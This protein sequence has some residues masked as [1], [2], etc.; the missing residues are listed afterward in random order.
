MTQAQKL[1]QST[2]KPAR[3]SKDS[4]YRTRK[5]WLCE[6]RIVGKAEYLAKG[7]N[8]RF[9]VTSIQSELIDVRALYEDFHCA[10]GE[11]ENWIKEQQLALFPDC[12]STSWMRSDQLRRYVSSFAFIWVNALRWLGLQGTELAKAQCETIRL[13]LFKIGAQIRPSVRHRLSEIANKNLSIGF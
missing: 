3:V 6:R 2:Q 4:R 5:S 13:K 10:C 7:E 11:M 8:P 9:I 1:H 12:T